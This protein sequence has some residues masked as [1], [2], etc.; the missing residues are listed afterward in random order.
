MQA[1]RFADSVAIGSTGGE[2]GGKRRH[3]KGRT[4][5][6]A[7][8]SAEEFACP[9]QAALSR[10]PRQ[11]LPAHPGTHTFFLEQRR[12]DASLFQKPAGAGKPL[13]LSA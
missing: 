11:P 12:Q 3:F 13:W 7:H 10:A 1:E 2:Q 5:A 9:A 4:A 8:R 6:A